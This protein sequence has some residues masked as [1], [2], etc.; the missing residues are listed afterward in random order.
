MGVWARWAVAVVTA[1]ALFGGCWLAIALAAPSLDTGTD[2]ALGSVPLVIALAV[3]GAWAEHAREKSATKPSET[4]KVKSSPQGQAIGQ[5]LGGVNIGPGA[6]VHL[7]GDQKGEPKALAAEE[8]LGGDPVIVGDIPQEP[9][10]FQP[11][12]GLLEM[13]A[14][15]SVS[16]VS[17]VLAVTGTRG[18]GKTQVAAAHAR[19]R[20]AQR[21][22]LVAWVDAGDVDSV[23]AGMAAIG[24][25]LGIGAA[26]ESTEE[27]AVR[28]RH[29]LE[30]SG[31]RSLV[32]FD[33]AANLDGLRPY[34]PAGGNA[35]IVITS[36][37]QTAANLG[38]AIPVDVFTMAEAVTFL[39]QRTGRAADEAGAREL[40]N[41]LGCLPLGLAQAAALIARE[42]LD[43]RT[44]LHRLRTLPVSSY[45]IRVEGDPYPH[46]V[47]RAILLSL[48]GIE[49]S[50]DTGLCA[51]VMDLVAF[52]SEA[53]MPRRMLHVA[54]ASGVLSN[55]GADNSTGRSRVS[56]VNVDAAVGRL[57]DASL[58]AFNLDESV[59][60]AHRLIMRVVRERSFA[61]GDFY[62]IAT[63]ATSLIGKMT[64]AQDQP[65]ENAKDAAWVLEVI[66]QHTALFEHVTANLDQYAAYLHDRGDPQSQTLKDAIRLNENM[67]SLLQD[68]HDALGI[69]RRL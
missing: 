24:A 6:V 62:T 38:A 13:L 67:K 22:Q 68:L 55:W 26:G 52:M 8:K 35:Q 51:A 10:A 34:L 43:Y 40:A 3:L 32:V 45:L 31:Q 28:V 64:S 5:M 1:L 39:A 12:S 59:L 54:A 14:G 42:R 50:D 33:N 47:A 69:E 49:E 61:K 15:E 63:A 9:T 23:R 11:R 65:T 48:K 44:Y 4:A 53:G 37:R 56:P 2:I 21:W 7:L 30:S 27:L 16:R 36:N 18:V 66:E 46:G 19:A 29:W 17:V 20:I 57:A 58:L 60:V 41:E 25:A